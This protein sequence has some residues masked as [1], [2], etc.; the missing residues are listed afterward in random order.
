MIVS[1]GWHGVQNVI[2]TSLENRILRTIENGLST[3]HFDTGAIIQAVVARVTFV[4]LTTLLSS[5]IRSTESLVHSRITHFYDDMILTA[6]L[7]M[8]LPMLQA[9]LSFDHLSS[10]APVEVFSHL[11]RLL[12]SVVN[13]LGHL[14]LIFMTV[15]AGNHGYAFATL[16]L[17]KPVIQLFGRDMIYSIP[18][19]VEAVDISFLRMYAL[20][21]L[22]DSKY[23]RDIVSGNITNYVIN[24]YRQARKA[25]G[26]TPIESAEAQYRLNRSPVSYIIA[27]TSGD[28]PVIYYALIAVLNPS[29]IS[30]ASIATVQQSSTLLQYA[31]FGLQYTINALERD[32]NQVQQVYDV[33]A[34]TK[35]IKD[36][37]LSYPNEKENEKGMVFELRN[38]S[39]SY[40]GSKLDTK[41][42]DDVSLRIEAGEM[43]V[44]V[45][46]NGSAIDDNDLGKSTFVNILTRLYDATSGEVLVD[47][48]DIKDYRLSD[49]RQAMGTLTQDH[50]LYP[51]SI[52]E[53]IGLGHAERVSDV[54]MIAEAAKKG[55]AEKL[56]HKLPSGYDTVLEPRTIQYGALVN[57]GGTGPLAE[58]LKK[59]EKKSDVS[60]PPVGGERQRLIAARTFMRLNSKKVKF[61]AVD[62]PTSALDPEGELELF[63]NLRAARRGKTMLFITHRFGPLTKH[64]DRIICM[65]DGRIV[66]CGNHAQLMAL[67]GE[68]CKMFNIQAQAFEDPVTS[69]AEAA[70]TQ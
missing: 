29:Q 23:R 36:G 40:P 43:I 44:V 39:F 19:V 46:A 57:E 11:L 48:E 54:D 66:E 18:R 70:H 58:Q 8:D 24:G 21:G 3:R 67:K 56:I 62:E 49:I 22:V 10:R 28:L 60:G 33:Q 52:G 13:S 38:V 1:Y 30:L 12:Q 35:T 47:G 6:K 16:C 64:A 14:S 15:R 27:Q 4:I 45:G 63:N 68:Y 61:L 9:N 42:L 50:H 34:M 32:A 17:F 7:Q 41:A 2:L 65:K 37:H 51:L 69:K 26:D 25:L 53:N 20:K 31:F 59:L 5:W 55:G